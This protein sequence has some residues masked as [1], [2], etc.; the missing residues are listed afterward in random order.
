M[1]GALWPRSTALLYMASLARARA[2]SGCRLSPLSSLPLGPLS[3][4]L[5]ASLVPRPTS[6]DTCVR[7][8]DLP[9]RRPARRDG[10]AKRYCVR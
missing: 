3:A 9:P 6:H 4:P 5:A 2:E 8:A 7:L 10:P 1:T